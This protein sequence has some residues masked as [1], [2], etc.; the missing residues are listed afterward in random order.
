MQT[1]SPEECNEIIQIGQKGLKES[2]VLG[3]AGKPEFNS[4]RNSRTKGIPPSNENEWIYKRLSDAA[5]ELNNRFFGF[6]LFGFAEFL[7]FAQ[8][9]AGG[10]YDLHVDCI[11]H[12]RIRKLSISVQL[13]EDYE[14]GNL[15]VNYGSDLVMPK[16][17]GMAIAFPST[18]LHS[19]QPVTKGTRYSLVGW[20][21]GPRFK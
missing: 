7:Q 15:V 21:T 6:D 9:E 2:L 19:V 5:Q 18:A 11:Y 17:T 20:I 3:A 1:F 10:K 8:Y 16:T 14:G 12:G 4:M 13:G